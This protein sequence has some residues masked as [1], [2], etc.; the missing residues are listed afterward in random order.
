[1]LPES[2]DDIISFLNPGKLSPID[3]A[4]IKKVAIKQKRERGKEAA[5]ENP[6]LHNFWTLMF[7]TVL[8]LLDRSDRTEDCTPYSVGPA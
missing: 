4:R 6:S 2:L 5:N 3:A 1:M 8:L 7:P